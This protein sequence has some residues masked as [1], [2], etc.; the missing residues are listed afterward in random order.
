[1][2]QAIGGAATEPRERPV[3]AHLGLA[4][5]P[6]A[7]ALDDAPHARGDRERR[8]DVERDLGP[9]RDGPEGVAERNVAVGGVHD[10]HSIGRG[11]ELV[12]AGRAR[13]TWTRPPGYARDAS[14]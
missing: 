1:M 10:R 4:A 5:H 7:H 14:S 9:L 2:E 11:G 13:P 8:A 12:K 3:P 6:E